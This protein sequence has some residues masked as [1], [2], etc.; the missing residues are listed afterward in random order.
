MKEYPSI[1]G[2][3]KAP[4]E[5]CIAFYKYDGSNI[6]VEWTKKNGFFKFGSRHILID[7]TSFLGD[8]I[9]IFKETYAEPLERIFRDNK[10]FRDALNITIF[11]EYFGANSF[12]GQH[13]DTDLKQVVIFDV[14]I[15]KKGF[16]PPRDFLK[17]FGHVKIPPVIYEGKFN[18]SFIQDVKNNKFFIHEGVVAKGVFPNRKPPH[19][20]WMAKCK[21]RDWM[22]KL[23]KLSIESPLK[24]GNMLQENLQEQEGK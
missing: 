15:H 4:R 21:T 3:N 10:I 18:E 17:I 11:G 23:K 22:E 14:N 19:N 8:S 2:P 5:N 13:I 7:E 20:L 9:K 24:Y 16:L 12:A 6:R 1:I